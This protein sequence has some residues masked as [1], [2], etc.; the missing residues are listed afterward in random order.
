MSIKLPDLEF[1]IKA[2]TGEMDVAAAKAKLLGDSIERN[3][4]ASSPAGQ[5]L[6][7]LGKDGE[8]ASLRITSAT[9]KT[10]ADM[11]LL[12]ARA[13]AA[14]DAIGKDLGEGTQFV[15][16]LGE[17]GS[18]SLG[19]LSQAAVGAVPPVEG[20]SASLAEL[21]PAGL[22]AGAALAGVAAYAAVA[23]AP[24]AALTAGIS[25]VLAL[26]GGV[27]GAF[28]AFGAGAV[29]LSQRVQGLTQQQQN[30]VAAQQQLTQATNAYAVAVKE[31]ETL[32]QSLKGHKATADQ[33]QLLADL[34][35]KAKTSSYDLAAAQNAVAAAGKV[36]ETPLQRLTD[37]VGKLADGLGKQATPAANLIYT[38]LGKLA[39][40]IEPVASKLLDWFSTRL[41]KVLP[42]VDKLVGDV[43]H[44]L[45][46]FG[47]R[48]GP[49]IDNWI[50]HP[51]NFQKTFK[52]VGDKVISVTGDIIVKAQQLADWWNAHHVQLERDATFVFNAIG[53][54]AQVTAALLGALSLVMDRFVLAW[55][56]A[57]KA[58][59]PAAAKISAAIAG[60]GAVSRQ[61]E[62]DLGR[63]VLALSRVP[64]AQGLT[65]VGAALIGNTGVLGSGKRAAGGPVMAG[66]VLAD[67]DKTPAMLPMGGSGFVIPQQK[68]R[69]L[70][71]QLADLADY[72]APSMVPLP[73]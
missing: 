58:V 12:G 56:A 43:G 47:A 55:E 2:N 19:K 42:I 50:K 59:A 4:G 62:D 71:E 25:A 15:I 52:D 48:L 16:R 24:I 70:R 57:A 13:R 38:W 35:Q 30:A 5:A 7:R 29:L 31:L 49:I 36:T 53:I 17:D 27:L 21:G 14:V 73:T 45:E 3:F 34:Q 51:E 23:V 33:L 9:A 72:F 10:G 60:I 64:G 8:L 67:G 26:G 37:H 41:P 40:R 32:Q 20:L 18:A 11:E 69:D 46:G 44:S 39:D 1:K 65:A 66:C 61:V 6:V 22:V 63:L 28:G 68:R 54:A